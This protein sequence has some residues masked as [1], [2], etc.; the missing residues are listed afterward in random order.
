MMRMKQYIRGF[1]AV[2]SSIKVPI[3]NHTLISNQLV[4]SF[5][6]QLMKVIVQ[7]RKEKELPYL[8]FSKDHKMHLK[9]KVVME[10]RWNF[11]RGTRWNVVVKT[12][13]P[14]RTQNIAIKG[15]FS[16]LDTHLDGLMLA[17]GYSRNAS[18]CQCLGTF[19]S[20]KRW[21]FFSFPFTYIVLAKS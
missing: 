6:I 17:G 8:Q 18:T 2:R 21:N 14:K 16:P 1:I 9:K 15:S 12:T 20:I 10:Q 19:I 11:G 13:G 5:H 4:M 3:N 7:K